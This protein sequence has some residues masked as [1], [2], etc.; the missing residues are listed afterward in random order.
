ML[1]TVHNPELIPL[2]FFL[3]AILVFLAW[4]VFRNRRW[5][6]YRDEATTRAKTAASEGQQRFEEAISISREQLQLSKEL[7]NEIKGLRDDL[8]KA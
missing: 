1:L 5:E 6:N 8:Q 4:S 3:G 7:L 2:L